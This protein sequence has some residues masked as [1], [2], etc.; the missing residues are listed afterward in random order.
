MARFCV[1]EGVDGTGK[2]HLAGKANEYL[3]ANGRTDVV[4][5]LKDDA[6]HA[7]ATWEARRLSAMHRLTWSYDEF[8]P[9]WKYS[10]QY[11]LFSLLAWYTLYYEKHVAPHLADGKTVVTDGWYFKHHARFMLSGDEQFI[12]LANLTLGTLPQPDVVAFL[13]LPIADAAARK[14]GSSNPSEHG[15]FDAEVEVSDV[16][17]FTDYQQRSHTALLVLLNEHPS[18]LHRVDSLIE[19]QGFINLLDTWPWGPQ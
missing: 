17:S 19:P 7:E 14:K 1:V 6:R 11:W 8:E 12:A 13:D 15:A 18:E 16:A 9:V 10:R 2:S 4:V 5:V 3:E